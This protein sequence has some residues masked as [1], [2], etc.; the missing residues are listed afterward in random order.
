ME[1][2]APHLLVLVIAAMVGSLGACNEKPLGSGF[3]EPLS[4]AAIK[5]VVPDP[6]LPGAAEVTL[7][8]AS[9]DSMRVTYNSTDGNDTGATPWIPGSGAPLIVLGLR[10]ATTYNM[11]VETRQGA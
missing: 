8:Q 2:P 3:T 11:T 4:P 1:R 6:G 7:T 5:S 10:S 9:S